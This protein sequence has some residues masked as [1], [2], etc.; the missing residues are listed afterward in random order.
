MKFLKKIFALCL[1]FAF[2]FG[3]AACTVDGT[4]GDGNEGGQTGPVTEDVQ[5][6]YVEGT[7]HKVTV[8]EANRPFVTPQGSDYQVVAGSS[9]FARTAANFIITHVLAATGVELPLL[10][11]A[12]W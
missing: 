11:D 10:L 7:L 12:D 2:V 5:L 8:T 9:N 4:G 1:A 6:H 3:A